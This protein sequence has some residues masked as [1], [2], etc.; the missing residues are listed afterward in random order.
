LD[1]FEELGPAPDGKGLTIA[2][3]CATYHEEVAE[4]M[5]LR[6]QERAKQAGCKLGPALKVR[7]SFDTALPTEWLLERDEVDAVIVMGS[8]VKGQT[9]HDEV[10][11][12]ATAATLQ[13]LS[14]EYD[15]PVGLAITGPGMTID[16][17]KARVDAGAKAVDACIAIIEAWRQ[18]ND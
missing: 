11:A 2:F 5:L 17:A 14:V 7:G 3:V 6:A 8:I 15:K 10:I 18:I 16:Q 13:A 1:L 4:Q 12:N 9:K